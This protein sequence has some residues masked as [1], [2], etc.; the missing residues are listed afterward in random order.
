MSL[1]KH[2]EYLDAKDQDVDNWQTLFSKTR[3]IADKF[4]VLERKLIHDL[5]PSELALLFVVRSRELPM[6][7]GTRLTLARLVDGLADSRSSPCEKDWREVRCGRCRLR[8]RPTTPW[9]E[10]E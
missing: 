6:T 1:M 8:L 3:H 2:S 4:G 5:S 7:L 10:N 9:L